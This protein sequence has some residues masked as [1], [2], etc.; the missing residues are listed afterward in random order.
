MQEEKKSA[1]IFSFQAYVQAQTCFSGKT[2]TSVRRNH[3]MR[4]AVP[5]VRVNVAYNS[6]HQIFSKIADNLTKTQ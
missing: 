2:R 3:H 6:G 1:E 4:L 5:T